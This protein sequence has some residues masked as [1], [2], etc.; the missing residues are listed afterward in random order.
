MSSVASAACCRALTLG[1]RLA[2]FGHR[3]PATVMWLLLYAVVTVA[4]VAAASPLSLLLTAGLVTVLGLRVRLADA[5]SRH[6]R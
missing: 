1:Q 5:D 6:P 4:A 3:R 2:R